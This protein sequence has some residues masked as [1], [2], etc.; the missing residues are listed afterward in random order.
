MLRMTAERQRQEL[1][2][3]EIAR[4]A[5]MHPSTISSIESGYITPSTGQLAKIAAV[6]AWEGEPAALLGD[7]S[8]DAEH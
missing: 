1:S 7:V 5:A 3:A 4:R 6:L 2:Q 8:T